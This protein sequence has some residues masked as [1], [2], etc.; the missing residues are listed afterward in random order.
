MAPVVQPRAV[1]M[2]PKRS[3]WF[4]AAVAVGLV[5]LS[6]VWGFELLVRFG[7]RGIDPMPVLPE[8]TVAPLAREALWLVEE[9]SSTT[10]V[11]GLWAGNFFESWGS[12]SRARSSQGRRVAGSLAREWMSRRELPGSKVRRS[13]MECALA[14]WLT[15]HAGV[16]EL[17]QAMAEWERFGRGAYGMN[18]AARAYFGRESSELTVSQIALLAGLP[19]APSR[20]NPDRSPEQAM[21]RRTYVLTQMRNQHLISDEEFSTAVNEAL[22]VIPRPSRCR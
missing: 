5:V 14:V 18:E 12:P 17:K 2:R 15:R 3:T 10:R 6:P 16:E 1:T 13:L 7:L 20:Y 21:K 19:Q 4:A 8:S 22:N 11:D 9:G